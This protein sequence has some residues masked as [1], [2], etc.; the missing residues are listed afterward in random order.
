MIRFCHYCKHLVVG[1]AIQARSR[2]A[3]AHFTCW[4]DG[5]PFE[6]PDPNDE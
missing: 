2:N 3:W 4:Y 5:G 6:H 1:K